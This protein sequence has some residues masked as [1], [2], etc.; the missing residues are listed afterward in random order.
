VLTEVLPT[1]EELAAIRPFYEALPDKH[2]GWPLDWGMRVYSEPRSPWLA[3]DF[4]LIGP[5]PVEVGEV[6]LALW[7]E[8]RAVYRLEED[9]SVG[10]DP[11]APEEVARCAMRT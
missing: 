6:R 5:H 4:P 7:R 1:T 8:T 10:E 9:M 3:V 11:I 2:E